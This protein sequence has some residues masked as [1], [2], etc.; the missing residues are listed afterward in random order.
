MPQVMNAHRSSSARA[1][2]SLA[3]FC[4]VTMWPA[5]EFREKQVTRTRHRQ[6]RSAATATGDSSTS[7]PS[8]EF[9]SVGNH[10]VA[11]AAL[12][13]RRCATGFPMCGNR[14]RSARATRQSQACASAA[15]PPVQSAQCRAPSVAQVSG[16]F[17]PGGICRPGCRSHEWWRA[18]GCGRIQ[19]RLEQDQ[20]LRPLA[21]T[22]DAVEPAAD[23]GRVDL[24]NCFVA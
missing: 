15:R 12:K 14:L 19:Q 8:S 4:S 22:F 9:L 13:C 1:N 3:C 20:T 5:A 18:H 11:A 7:R 17:A 24:S 23:H 16:R 2:A 10:S 6:R 21:T